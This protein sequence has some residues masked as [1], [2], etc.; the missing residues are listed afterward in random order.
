MRVMSA[1]EAENGY[2]G[3]LS[4]TSDGGGARTVFVRGSV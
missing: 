2:G 1:A 4:W 3:K